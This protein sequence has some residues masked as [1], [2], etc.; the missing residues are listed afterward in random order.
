MAIV[1]EKGKYVRIDVEFWLDKDG[2]IHLVYDDGKGPGEFFHTTVNDRE[3]SKRGHPNLFNHLKT[4]L[5]KHDKWN[6]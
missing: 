3:V 6:E 5:Q 1:S 2:S 4:V